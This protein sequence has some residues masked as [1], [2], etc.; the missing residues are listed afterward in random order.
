MG[1]RA[2]RM[3]ASGSALAAPRP[4]P[5]H[6]VWQGLG[7]AWETPAA[8]ADPERWLKAAKLVP[9]QPC[10][11]LDPLVS[12]VVLPSFS[13]Q[14]LL[15]RASVGVPLL[16][17]RTSGLWVVG[18]EKEAELVRSLD[19]AGSETRGTPETGPGSRRMLIGSRMILRPETVVGQ[20]GAVRAVPTSRTTASWSGC[21]TFLL[22]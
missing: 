10:Y 3:T 20:L 5:G 17:R 19:R 15:C 21:L 14:R 6:A 22:P 7:L 16:R 18:P 1:R 13:F 11:P 2:P 4:S 8:Q 9:H 12:L